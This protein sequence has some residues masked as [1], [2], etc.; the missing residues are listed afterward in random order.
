MNIDMETRYAART[1]VSENHCSPC[2]TMGCSSEYA[3]PSW[4]VNRAWLASHWMCNRNLATAQPPESTERPSVFLRPGPLMGYGLLVSASSVSDSTLLPGNTSEQ[5]KIETQRELHHTSAL[6]KRLERPTRPLKKTGMCLRPRFS[7]CLGP[8]LESCRYLK[9]LG[10]QSCGETT[11]IRAADSS[12]DST[13]ITLGC[14]LP[15]EC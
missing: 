2:Q 3:T 10:T 8:R 13:S 12:L 1:G 11:Q 4:S 15:A 7:Q 5:L 9:I 6:G 14:R